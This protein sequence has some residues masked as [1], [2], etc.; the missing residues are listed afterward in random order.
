[1]NTFNETY[2]QIKVWRFTVN[3][4]CPLYCPGNTGRRRPVDES[5]IAR[6]P[7]IV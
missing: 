3:K 6:V 5:R 4:Q 7:P 2:I 1:M